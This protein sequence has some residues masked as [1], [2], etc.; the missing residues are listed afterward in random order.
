MFDISRLIYSINRYTTDQNNK[1]WRFN[2]S[3]PN[4]T[5]T[6]QYEAKNQSQQSLITATGIKIKFD[7]YNKNCTV[8]TRT[9]FSSNNTKDVQ[10]QL[11]SKRFVHRMIKTPK[12]YDN[13]LASKNPSTSHSGSLKTNDNNNGNVNDS[14]FG[15]KHISVILAEFLDDYDH[16]QRPGYGGELIFFHFQ[17]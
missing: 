1:L 5:A 14:S 7:N 11:R 9:E 16:N 3:W 13:K 6:N 10:I 17:K 8:I 15:S 2:S 12:L 4:L